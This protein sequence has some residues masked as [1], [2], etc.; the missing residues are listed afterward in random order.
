MLPHDSGPSL[1]VHPRA[2]AFHRS[3]F[4][5]LTSSHSISEPSAATPRIWTY[6]LLCFTT[7]GERNVSQPRPERAIKTPRPRGR[8]VDFI[9]AHSIERLVEKQRHDNVDC[10]CDEVGGIA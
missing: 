1:D 9:S 3:T 5:P 7:S 4:T 2:C 6:A 8:K 10:I